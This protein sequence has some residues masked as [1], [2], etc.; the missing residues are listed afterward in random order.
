MLD[1]AACVWFVPQFKIAHAIFEVPHD[2]AYVLQVTLDFLLGGEARGDL[3]PA[4]RVVG[5]VPK[6][7]DVGNSD[8]ALG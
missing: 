2:K 7:E 4:I 3:W 8:A 1:G 6:V 5:F